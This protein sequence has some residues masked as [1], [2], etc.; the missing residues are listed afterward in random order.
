LKGL[1]L[2]DGRL[3][4]K[5]EGKVAMVTGGG[6]GMGRSHCLALAR[7]GADIVTFD[8]CKDLPPIGYS[9]S[10]NE[11]L[12]ETVGQVKALGRK[13]ISLI[14]DVSK[15][16][17][18]KGVVDRAID[19]FGK[20]DILVNNAGIALIGTPFHEVTEEQWDMILNVNLKGSWLCCK[21]VIPHM[22][23]QKRGKIINIASHCGLIGIATIGPYTCAKH[24]IIG[25]TR[26]LAAELAPLGINVNA[27]C[28]AA[29]DT[30]ML[31]KSFEQIGMTFEEAEKEWGGAS[32]VPHELIPPEDISKVVVWLA[33]EDS[34]FLHGRSI[35]VGASTG[36][37]P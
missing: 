22:I 24:G 7:E 9:L 35:L 10:R 34:R 21:Y 2:E 19:K 13:A 8:I 1:V 18:V 32:V 28:P 12:D 36:L 20:I 31:S 26:T 17:E 23:K 25:L 3:N 5:L 14:A 15:A 16:Q 11:E 27:I 29:V 6:R 33:S 4:M 30:P 37:I